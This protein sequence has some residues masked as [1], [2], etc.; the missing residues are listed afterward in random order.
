MMPSFQFPRLSRRFVTPYLRQNQTKPTLFMLALH[1]L[2]EFACNRFEKFRFG[3]SL[4]PAFSF[5]IFTFCCFLLLTIGGFNFSRPTGAIM[6]QAGDC[7]MGIDN[8][9]VEVLC[10]SFK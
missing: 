2:S 3:F 5:F 9:I 8:G 10:L 1:H 7:R 6:R 4:A